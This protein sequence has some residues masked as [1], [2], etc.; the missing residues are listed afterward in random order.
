[1]ALVPRPDITTPRALDLRAVQAAVASARQRVEAIEAAVNVL[2]RTVGASAT[3]ESIA[4]LTAQVTQ[5][6]RTVNTLFATVASDRAVYRA[7]GAIEAL[8][9]VYPTSD[10]GVSQV[11]LTDP[12]AV[13]AT[14]GVAVVGAAAT[15]QVT[16]QQSGYLEVPGASFTTGAPVFV[17]VDGL[18]HQPDYAGLVL[19]MG[20]AVGAS[21]MWVAPGWPSVQAPGAYSDHELFL[22]VTLG[23]VRETL[24][25]ING[26]LMGGDG[27]VVKVGNNLVTREIVSPSGGGLTVTDGDGVSGNPTITAP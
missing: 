24:D 2:Q 13:Y 18:T 27:I 10:G 21:A 22:P 26:L 8:H 5:L 15:A 1:M 20:T 12:R 17:G 3:A 16:V 9:A 19:P 6:T 25:L 14:V 4:T 23:L 11:D 7:D